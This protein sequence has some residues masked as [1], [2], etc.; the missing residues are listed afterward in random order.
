M[1]S[2]ATAV[3]VTLAALVAANFHPVGL[4]AF[5]DERLAVASTPDAGLLELIVRS[6]IGRDIVRIVLDSATKE[7]SLALR[8]RSMGW[9]ASRR[10]GKAPNDGSSRRGT[11]GHG[12]STAAL[13]DGHGSGSLAV[14]NSGSYGGDIRARVGNR[15]SSGYAV[16]GIERARQERVGAGSGM[17]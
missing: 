9:K 8:N 6:I 4:F 10:R 1:L 15:L 16:G 17:G 5:L 12:V 14:P 3:L 2:Q 13:G 7:V 11:L